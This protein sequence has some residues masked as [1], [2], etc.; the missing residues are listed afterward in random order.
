[1]ERKKTLKP[2]TPLQEK[3]GDIVIKW[4][5]RANTWLYRVSGGRLGGRWL[6]GAPVMLLTT[7]GRKSG[8]PR[9]VPLLYLRDG[10]NIVC[11]ASK[12]GMSKHPLWYLNLEANP[13]C[14]VQIGRQRLPMRA[15]RA[16]DAEKAELW[17]RLVAMYPD[18][19]DYQARTERNIPV[20]ILSPRGA[21]S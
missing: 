11:V 16:S 3:I 13:D 8:Q 12:G 20:V 5:S 15:R 14:E 10:E 17:P 18:Y 2:Y 19:E 9:T 4:M 21:T 7:I 6:R 1:M